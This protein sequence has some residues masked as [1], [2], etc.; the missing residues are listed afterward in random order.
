M[1]LS[2]LLPE[3]IQEK[4][5]TVFQRIPTI[6]NAGPASYSQTRIWVDE[7]AFEL[8]PRYEELSV[9]VLRWL[10]AHVD[11][12]VKIAHIIP[13]LRY[14]SN[15]LRIERGVTTFGYVMLA[16][17]EMTNEV[18]IGNHVRLSADAYIQCHTLEQRSLKLASVTVNHSC[19]LMSYSN[20]LPGSTLH[21]RNQIL[22]YTLVM[23]NDQLP[24][25]TNW[26]GVPASQVI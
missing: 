2:F 1:K 11:N 9:A 17:F 14:P 25:N 5:Q 3:E 20:L 7:K 15:L 21:G 4:E 23:K 18:T 22:P 8:L 24:F 26:S 13:I 12:D 19:I 16:P 6:I 10:G